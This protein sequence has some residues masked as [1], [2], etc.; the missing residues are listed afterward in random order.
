M[1]LPLTVGNTETICCLQPAFVKVMTTLAS[2]GSSSWHG[3][4]HD[5]P[6]DTAVMAPVGLL[7]ACSGSVEPRT[8]MYGMK[9]SLNR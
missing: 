6:D 3:I 5:E 7:A 8:I 9:T 4:W 2:R 1:P